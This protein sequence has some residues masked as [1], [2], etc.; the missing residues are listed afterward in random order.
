MISSSFFSVLGVNP[1]LGRD[2]RP[3][4][5]QIG[6]APV[7]MVGDG[8]WKRRFAGSPDVVG[9][10]LTLDGINYTVVGV[11]PGHSPIFDLASDVYVPIGQWN[12]ETFRN[13]RVS[14]GMFA[15][16]RLKPGVALQQA[17]ADMEGIARGLAVAYP[18]SNA[19]TS[20]T[21]LPLKQEIVGNIQP[22]LLVLL[23]AVGFV[24]LISCANVANLLLARSTGRMREFAIR[25]AVGATQGRVVRQLLTES[26][27][28]ALVG[29]AL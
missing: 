25:A 17:T 6:A 1:I 21:V 10:T 29:G 13:R 22:F 16:G 27:I 14:M 11:M 9:K 28:L 19:D 24:L 2:F 15:V 8:F 7:A 4:E 12:D 23:A 26:V 20:V 18:E 3:E 5:D